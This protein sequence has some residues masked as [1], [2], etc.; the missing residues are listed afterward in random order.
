[1]TEKSPL[2]TQ[3]LRLDRRKFVRVN[4]Y[5]VSRYFCPSCD[6]EVGIQTL[7]SDISE[8]GA[9]LVTFDEGIPVGTQITMNFLLPNTD[10]LVSISGKIRHTGI[11]KTDHY[12]SG[13]EFEKLKKKDRQAIR[14]YVAVN[15][16][17]RK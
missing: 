10:A 3:G 4:I 15:L 14:Q 8:G 17:E 11:L 5:A 13:L 1:M 16:R 2:E 12:R 7:I 9:F 6:Q